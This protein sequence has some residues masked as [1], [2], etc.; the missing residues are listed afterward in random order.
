MRLTAFISTVLAASAAAFAVQAAPLGPVAEIHVTIG[1]QLQDKADDY[2]QRELDY[3]AGDLRKSVE[4]ALDRSGGLA[5]AGGTLDLVIEDAIPNRPTLRQM[6]VKPSLSYESYGIGGARIGG[7]LTTADGQRIPV[8][9]RWYETD[10][11]WS[12]TANTWTD[13]QNTF[14]RFA[15]RLVTGE[16]VAE[17]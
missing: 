8:G 10:I 17:R 12:Q 2:G 13:A 6:A 7:V 4:Q 5:A 16:A 11:R 15:R 9:F 14:D 1:P 3:L